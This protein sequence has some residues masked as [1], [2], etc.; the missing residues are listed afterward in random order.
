MKAHGNTIIIDH[1]LGIM[2]IHCHLKKRM[3]KAGKFVNKG[4]LIGI[5]GKS[6]IA[7]GENVHFGISVND[8]RVDPVQFIKSDITL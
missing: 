8:V 7:T 5:L 1:G 6:G 3:V 4:E 2:S